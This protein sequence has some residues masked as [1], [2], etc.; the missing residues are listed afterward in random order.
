MTGLDALAH[1]VRLRIV[2]HLSDHGPA[3]LGELAKAAD[4]HENTARTHIA[5]LQDG[6]V[7]SA[8]RRPLDRPGRPGVNYRLVDAHLIVPTPL[9]QLL[10]AALDRAGPDPEQLRAT[11]RDW[12]RYL[13]GPPG[14]H[15]V[16]EKLPEVLEHVGYRCTVRGNAVEL[17]GCP[18]KSVLPGRPRLICALAEGVV[19]GALAATSSQRH[20]ASAEHDP[21]AR[22]SRLELA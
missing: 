8:E 15:D 1:P 9:A 7:I 6:G 13:A 16:E 18:C 5:A 14:S 10:A 12:G 11:G 2:R 22:R 19:D 4:V 3:S 20:V 17:S 21:D